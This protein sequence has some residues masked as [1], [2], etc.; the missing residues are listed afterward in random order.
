M[1]R[2]TL[3]V[4][5]SAA[6]AAGLAAALATGLAANAAQR[7]PGDAGTGVRSTQNPDDVARYWTEER[8]ERA[9]G[10]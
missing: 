8:K 2:R 6:V 9:T 3:V 1:K 10:G 7:S 5:A 4:V